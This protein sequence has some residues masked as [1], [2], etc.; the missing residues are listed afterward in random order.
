MHQRQFAFVFAHV[1]LGDVGGVDHLLHR[2]QKPALGHFQKFLGERRR[3]RG[4]AFVHVGKE[5]VGA[6]QLVLKL[7]FAVAHQMGGLFSAAG[8]GFD[9]GED[10]LGLDGVDV[11]R[12]ID[13]AVHMDD[14]F[15]LKAAHHVDDGVHLADVGEELVAQTLAVAGALD[16]TG[17]VDKL[18][19][20]RV[21]F[22]G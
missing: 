20:R 8:D 9:V 18:Q 6:L 2:Q 4:L 16:Q 10:Q 5:D 19:R 3:A 17:D 22:S 14:V 13:A 12:G 7:L 21:Y 1:A 15:V 11:A